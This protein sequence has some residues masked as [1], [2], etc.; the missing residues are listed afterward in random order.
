METINK[1]TSNETEIQ[2]KLDAIKAK[3]KNDAKIMATKLKVQRN[4]T[5]PEY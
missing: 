5:K 1:N 2:K 4:K 3:S